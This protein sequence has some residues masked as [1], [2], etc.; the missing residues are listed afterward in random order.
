MLSKDWNLPRGAEQKA[1]FIHVGMN[2]NKT[3]SKVLHSPKISDIVFSLVI[4]DHWDVYNQVYAEIGHITL[5]Q[6]LIF[7]K[8]SKMA[9]HCTGVKRR[10]SYYVNGFCCKVMMF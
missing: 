2:K 3:L 10:N 1:G 7:K 8:V 5:E 9:V 6:F 4:I